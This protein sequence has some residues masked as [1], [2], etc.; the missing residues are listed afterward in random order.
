MSQRSCINK[1]KRGEK[2]LGMNGKIAVPSVSMFTIFFIL[3]T[4]TPMNAI[5]DSWA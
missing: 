2:W 3:L 1:I 4:S 5:Y